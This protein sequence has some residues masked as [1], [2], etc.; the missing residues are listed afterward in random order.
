MKKYVATAAVAF[1]SVFLMSACGGGDD[2][3]ASS[4]PPPASDVVIYASCGNFPIYGSNDVFLTRWKRFPVKVGVDLSSAPRFNEGN[5]AAIY[6]RAIQA[7][8]TAWA[9]AGNG[10]GLVEFVPLAQAD[11]VVSFASLQ[12]GLLGV[13]YG[14]NPGRTYNEKGTRIDL[15]IEAWSNLATTVFFEEQLKQ[16]MTHEMGHALFA[17]GHSG[18]PG[19]MMSTDNGRINQ[20][21]VNSIREAYCRPL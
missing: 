13:A 11:L 18:T 10:I 4:S 3:S 21:D 1:A 16:T 14:W 6:N 20:R 17:R 7:G 19:D 9:V 5:N 12:P 15:N 2:S 8:A